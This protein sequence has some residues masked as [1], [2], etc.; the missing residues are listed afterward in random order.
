[1][2]KIIVSPDCG[3]S[4]KLTFVKDFNVAFAQ[5]D[6]GTLLERVTDDVTWELVGDWKLEGID[7]FRDELNKM[8]DFK[9]AEAHIQHVVT[10]GKEGAASGIM[11]GENGK[12]FAF[13]EFYEFNSAKVSKMKSIQSCLVEL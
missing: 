9:V 8:K 10:H 1:M 2:T 4:P 7:A 6:I 12:I 11:I 5:G 3:N 13:A